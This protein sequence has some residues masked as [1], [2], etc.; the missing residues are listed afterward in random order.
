MFER[1]DSGAGK[2]KGCV[3]CIV[4]LSSLISMMSSVA[5]TRRKHSPKTVLVK[6]FMYNKGKETCCT[7]P[8]RS[9]AYSASS[10][11]SSLNAHTFVEKEHFRSLRQAFTKLGGGVL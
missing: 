8:L 7:D 4:P 10:E 1:K 2:K 3:C 6:V 5:K 9:T 11:S